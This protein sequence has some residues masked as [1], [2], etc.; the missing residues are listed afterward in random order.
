MKLSIIIP[1]YNAE[2]YLA[3]CLDSIV[4]QSMDDDFEVILIDDG[5]ID[6]TTGIAKKYIKKDPR[7]RMI[8]QANAGVSAARNAGLELAKG[9]WVL[10]VD[11]D[12][13]L[14]DGALETLC[15]YTR[16]DVDLV[17]ALHETFDESGNSRIVPPET[18]WMD[19]PMDARR[20]AAALRL[21]EGDSV[22]NIMCNKLHRRETL[23][24]EGII[25]DRN[26]RIAEDALFNL[27][28]VLCARRIVFC[29]RVTYRYRIHA[30]SATQT[31]GKAEFE[32]HRP[33]FSSM[34][35]MLARRGVFEKYYPAYVQ[36]V[37]LR[38]YKDG[39]VGGVMREFNAKARTYALAKCDAKKLSLFGRALYALCASGMYP[40]V[41][42]LIFPFELV[43][44]KM[45][46]A[47]FALRMRGI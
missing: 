27:E 30:A 14:I 34:A 24:R 38:L 4:H 40:A 1:C 15:A 31:R 28:A 9:E 6:D 18:R 37:V 11:A 13:L 8:S 17:V 36:S 41:Y 33:W 23:T 44:R 12:D 45:R 42:P 47:T 10:F 7:I 5:S 19:Q 35:A 22:L 3:P 32:T 21:I 2:N 39:G 29:N 20:H 16:Q 43:K 46:E 26:V 25:L